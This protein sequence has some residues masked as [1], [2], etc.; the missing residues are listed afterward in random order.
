MQEAGHPGWIDYGMLGLLAIIWGGSF[1]LSRVAVAEMPP[2]TL[3]AMRQAIAVAI[4]A[5]VVLTTRQVLGA[6]RKDHVA[7]FLSA[8]FGMALPFFLITWGL[9]TLTAGYAAILMGLMPLM[10]ILLAHF[11]TNNEPMNSAKLIGVAFGIAGLVVLFWPDVVA[12]TD[13]DIWSQLAILG[14]GLCYAINALITKKLVH[15]KPQPM[16]LVN[17]GW[18]FVMLAL[19]A[20]IF[21]PMMDHNP[22]FEAWLSVVLLGVGPTA[23]A[24]LMLFRIIARQG[25]SFFSQINLLVP[26]AGVLWGAIIL[27]ERLSLNAFFALAIILSG[28]AVARLHPK[29]KLNSVE[30]K[31]S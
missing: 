11:F 7:I 13:R 2:L 20:I 12:G 14:A 28:V 25:A 17:V 22:S 21:E 15:L 29:P 4:F 3:T 18:S 16:F 23:L 5:G 26:V 10:T 8:F 1:M 19:A 24:S 30:G 6:N 27:D 31:A 9:G